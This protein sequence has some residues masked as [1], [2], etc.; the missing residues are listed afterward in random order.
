LTSTEPNSASPGPFLAFLSPLDLLVHFGYYPPEIVAHP[1]RPL[2]Q[3]GLYGPC[4]N[5]IPFPRRRGMGVLLWRKER[6]V[7]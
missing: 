4:Q 3:R 5:E 6:N 2:T 7:I 1:K